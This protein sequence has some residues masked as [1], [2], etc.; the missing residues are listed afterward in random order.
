MYLVDLKNCN[1]SNISTNSVCLSAL[2]TKSDC[3][4]IN[5]FTYNMSN[6]VDDIL[7]SYQ[8]TDEE[9]KK[10]ITVMG[11]FLEYFVK[12]RNVICQHSKF[13]RHV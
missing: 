12:H 2:V 10:C 1:G 4:Q 7:L 6:Q 5:T 13:N 8:L 11:K 9:A 3:Y